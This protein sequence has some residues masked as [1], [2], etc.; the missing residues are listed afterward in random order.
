M[1]TAYT[2]LL[3]LALPVTGELS[4]TWGDTVNNSITSLL[5]SAVSG[6][7]TISADADITLSTTTGAANEA[8]EAIILWTAGGTVTR[9]I[10]APAQ[11]KVYVVINKSSNTQS[12][13]LRGVGP[14]TGVTIALNEK[15]VCAWN[16]S[17]FVK[18]ASTVIT[19]LTGTLPVANGGTGLTSGTSGGVPY[20]SATGTIASSAALAANAIVLGGGAGVTPATTTTGTGVVTA[21]GVNVGTAG[22]FVVNGGA[23]GTP[24]SGTLTSATG[25]PLSTGVTGTLPATN[26]G[27]GQS[28]YAVGDLLYASTTTALSKLADVATGNALISGG[29]STAPSWGKI[30][31]TTHVSGNLPVTNLNSGTSAS[32]TTFW[33]GDGS[34]ATPAGG[35]STITISNKTAAYTVVA[36]DNGTVINCTSGTFTV[37]LT[38]A[39]TLATGFNVRIINTGTGTITIDPS[40]AE[41][42]D[43][44]TT[45][46][47]SKGQGVEIV[48]NGTNF[49]TIAIRTSGQAANTVALGNNSGATPSVAITGAGAMALGGSYASGTDSFAA[50]ISDN[51]SA[52]G[53]TATSAVAIGSIAAASATYSFALGQYATASFST[54]GVF[55]GSSNTASRSGAVA[56]G[57]ADNA[58]SGTK[59]AV[60]GGRYGSTRGTTGKIVSSASDSPIASVLGVSQLGMLVLGRQT[61]DATATVLAS[62]TAAASSD[63]QIT[64]PNNS[65]YYFRGEIIAGVTG[66]GNTKGFFIEGVI[67]RGANAAATSLVGT[68]TVTSNYADAGAS[69]WAVAVTANAT[70]GCLTITCTGQASTTIRWVAQVRTTEMTY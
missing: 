20:Y 24:S 17:D 39:A 37:S 51:N 3:G 26:G 13:V 44:N 45:W 31:L 41:T 70:L 40:G 63:N 57:G 30:G 4:G 8:R 10:T 67:K 47:L 54:A 49:F 2:S 50:A 62:D 55:A 65:A 64:L 23:L 59:S 34:W 29:V 1:A 19:N 11:S 18:V 25:L 42:I 35:S 22:A 58:A 7:T 5:D 52:Y 27:T 38:A 53:A 68:P 14:T 21:L 36:G 33:R 28:S 6:T 66:G 32:A 9:N 15:A 56:L 61:T 60:I 43:N 12:I 46:Q 16:G 69:T 48:C